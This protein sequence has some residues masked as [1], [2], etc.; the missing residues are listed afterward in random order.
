M[1]ILTLLA[2]LLLAVSSRA[3]TLRAFLK[4]SGIPDASFTKAELDEEINGSAGANQEIVLA[5]YVR[6][7]G[8]EVVGDPRLVHYDRKSGAIQRAEVKPEDEDRCCGSPDDLMLLRDFAIISFHI[9][10][11]AETMLVVGKDLKL[12][13]TLYGFNVREVAPGQV[14]FIENMIHFAAEHPERLAFADLRTGTT[15]ELYP[16]RGDALRAAFAREHARHLP[17][18]DTCEKMNDPCTPEL[19]DEDIDFVDVDGHGS[20]AFTVQRDALHA[21]A[22]E[23]PPE[24]VVSEAALY[25]YA[26]NGNNWLYCEEKLTEDAAKA[27]TLHPGQ[28]GGGAASGCCTPSLPVTADTANSDYSPFESHGETPAPKK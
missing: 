27:L 23:Q 25:R 1:R 18:H 16:P 6:V 21:T 11:D 10:P 4:T 2:A 9:N 20:F 26:W 19:Y 12:V 17:P 28:P 8:D 15:R 3:E 14:V 5:A 7:K 22:S 13:T 24:S